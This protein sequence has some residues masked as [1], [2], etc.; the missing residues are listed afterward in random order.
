M[1]V[2]KNGDLL[3]SQCDVICHQVNLDGIMGG[4][5]ALQIAR[6]YPEV[7]KKYIEFLR[8]HDYDE[9]LLGNYCTKTVTAK[10]GKLM[11]ANCFTQHYNY[12]TCYEAIYKCFESLID[13]MDLCELKTIGIPYGYGCGIAKEEWRKVD[14]IIHEVF[15]NSEVVCEVWKL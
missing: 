5:L 15:D 1:V 10:W 13:L 7:E 3:E 12:T 2:Y 6:K 9:T 8:Y 4:G 14:E 11:I